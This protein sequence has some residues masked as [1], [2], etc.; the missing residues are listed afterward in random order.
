M[1]WRLGLRSTRT[2]LILGIVLGLVTETLLHQYSFRVPRPTVALDAPFQ[3]GCKAPDVHAP[4]E[5]ATIL[6]LARNEDIEKAA[7]SISSLERH[8]NQ[9]FKY[10]ITFLNNE[11]W[12]EEFVT[13]MTDLISGE[14]NFVVIPS[15]M[16][17]YPDWVDQEK[18]RKSIVE[19]GARKIYK[20]AQESYHHMCRFFSGYV[21]IE[22]IACFVDADCRWLANSTISRS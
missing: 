13:T 5:N 14:A 9:W 10:P 21:F 22:D 2:K 18:A 8:F 17:G 4:R 3:V 6:M 19:Q 16:F 15:G 12:S 7:A 1:F 20:A 11:P